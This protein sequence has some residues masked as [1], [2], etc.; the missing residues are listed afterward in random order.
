MK[1]LLTGAIRICIIKLLQCIPLF[2]R[3]KMLKKDPNRTKTK[4]LIETNKNYK[5]KRLLRQ[6]QKDPK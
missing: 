6:H 4:D 2:V 5:R 3:L 1:Y